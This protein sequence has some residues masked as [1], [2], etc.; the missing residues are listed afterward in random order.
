[1]YKVTG[2]QT[3][4]LPILDLDC[5]AKTASSMLHDSSVSFQT[6]EK[7][8]VQSAPRQQHRNALPVTAIF[9]AEHADEVALFEHDADEDVGRGHRRE[10]Q[11]PGAHRR[12]RPERDDETEIDRVADK[13][14]EEWRPEHRCRHLAAHEIV[15]DLM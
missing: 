2:V 15:G 10:Q 6:I 13:T 8:S 3:C 4:A 11:M 5:T 1:D 12:G 9:V 7:W 14:I